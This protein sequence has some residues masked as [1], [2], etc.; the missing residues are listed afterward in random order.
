MYT[1]EYTAVMSFPRA[2][3]FSAREIISFISLLSKE[4]VSFM[5]FYTDIFI[6]LLI[7]LSVNLEN[8]CKV[9]YNKRVCIYI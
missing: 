1:R 2:P 3:P 9:C 8:Y 4:K 7:F 5:F 6:I